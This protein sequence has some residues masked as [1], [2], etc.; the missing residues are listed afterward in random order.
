MYFA[1]CFMMC[2]VIFFVISSIDGFRDVLLDMLAYVLS[3]NVSETPCTLENG[4]EGR[5]SMAYRKS[6]PCGR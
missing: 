3:L 4:A 2:Y 1:M 6:L 5:R